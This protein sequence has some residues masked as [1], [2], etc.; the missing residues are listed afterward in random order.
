[1][2]KLIFESYTPPDIEQDNPCYTPLGFSNNFSSLVGYDPLFIS[3]VFSAIQRISNAIAQMPWELKSFED[4]KIPKSHYFYTLFDNCKQTRFT[5]IKNIIKD[6]IING[7]GYAYIQKDGTK[8]V[9]LIYL[10]TGTCSPQIDAKTFKVYYNVN[11]QNIQRT[12]KADEILHFFMDSTDGL[13]GTPLLYFANKSIKLS[14]YTD[15]AALDYYQSGM[16]ITGVLSTDSPRLKP[17]QRKE[18]RDNYLA[19]MQE[20]GGI[21]VLEGNMHFENMSNNA[22]DASLIDSRQ[23]NVNDIARYFNISP[24]LLGNLEHTQYGSIE[25][26]STDFVSSTLSPWIIMI[27][28]ELNRKLLLQSAQSKYY[29]DI[30]EEVLIKTDRASYASYISTLLDKGVISINE[31]RQMLRYN[32]IEG[33]DVYILPYQGQKDDNGNIIPGYNKKNSDY[34]QVKTDNDDKNIDTQNNETD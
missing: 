32:K 27:E 5:F 31:A 29:I 10:P 23:Y 8:P 9:N 24:V 15:K 14:W 6:V 33:G 22:K 20:S 17:E 2:Q 16:R 21:A 4:V 1:M 19:G 7:N 26:A 25:Q 28:E 11:Y 18:I 3:P 34:Q 13:I 12:C 30:N